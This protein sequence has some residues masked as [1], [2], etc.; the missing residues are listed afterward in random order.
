LEIEKLKNTPNKLNQKSTSFKELLEAE[1]KRVNEATLDEPSTPRLAPPDI[2]PPPNSSPTRRYI[3]QVSTDEKS[4]QK[5]LQERSS[6]NVLVRFT[7]TARDFD[8]YNIDKLNESE[9]MMRRTT[10][11]AA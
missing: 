8:F 2:A 3:H 5:R 1:K 9:M 10:I 11:I 4:I 6:S 7:P